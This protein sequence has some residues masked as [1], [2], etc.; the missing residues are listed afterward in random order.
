M[1]CFFQCVNV[2]D[3][4]RFSCAYEGASITGKT[5]VV[6]ALEGRQFDNLFGIASDQVHISIQLDRGNKLP[7]GGYANIPEFLPKPKPLLALDHRSRLD[8]RDFDRMFG[9]QVFQTIFRTLIDS[10]VKVLDDIVFIKFQ[11]VY[12]ALTRPYDP[13]TVAQDKEDVERVLFGITHHEPVMFK[14]SSVSEQAHRLRARSFSDFNLSEI[15]ARDLF[16][17]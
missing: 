12:E 8:R 9:L 13:R 16:I 6:S 14:E 5:D 1:V 17:G 15:L 7:I 4:D 11:M 10:E 3:F 2:Y